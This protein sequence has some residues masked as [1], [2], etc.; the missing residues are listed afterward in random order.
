[1]QRAVVADP[2]Y[3]AGPPTPR[4]EGTRSRKLSFTRLVTGIHFY[5][6][7][8]LR[9]TEQAQCQCDPRALLMTCF[10]CLQQVHMSTRRS[11]AACFQS[12]RFKT[13]MSASSHTMV[14]NSLLQCRR[15]VHSTCYLAP[16]SMLSEDAPSSRT[17]T[18]TH[19][20]HSGEPGRSSRF[21]KSAHSTAFA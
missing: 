12:D 19:P 6:P 14:N 10:S 21:F 17:A 20:S 1:M 7:H 4:G 11:T 18:M 15:R 9:A 16:P 13:F 3:E 5:V 2:L 8:L